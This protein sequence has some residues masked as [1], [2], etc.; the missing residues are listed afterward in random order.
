VAGVLAR[1]QRTPIFSVLLFQAGWRSF[2]LPGRFGFSADM[3]PSTT[4]ELVR[5]SFREAHSSRSGKEEVTE[6]QIAYR[7][8]FATLAL[9]VTSASVDAGIFNFNATT[10]QHPLPSSLSLQILIPDAGVAAT[11]G[12]VG[13][14]GSGNVTTNLDA[15]NSGTVQINGSTLNLANFG[16][17]TITLGAFGGADASLSNVAVN[18]VAGPVPV[19]GRNFSLNSSSPGSITVNSGSVIL[20]N[21][22]GLLGAFLPGGTSIDFSA[23]PVSLPFSSLGAGTINGT[24]DDDTSGLDPNG[25]E[26]N[27]PL[28]ATIQV[29]SLGSLPVFARIFGNV[30][31]GS[32]VTAIPE[33]GSMVLLGLA[34]VAAFG[35]TRIRRSLSR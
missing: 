28:D 3:P 34:G 19:S 24:T 27:I 5:R 35:F 20:S 32:S 2:I 33:A 10:G 4:G 17:Q 8:V 31:L 22:T 16:P 23:N 1:E 18:I 6:M 15:G 14:S 30:N 12:P 7:A 11:I 21:P 9:L 29:T 13:V 26:V 25:A